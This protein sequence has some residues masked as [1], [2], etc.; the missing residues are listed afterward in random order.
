M[1]VMWQSNMTRKTRSVGSN[2]KKWGPAAMAGRPLGESQILG[3]SFC[4]FEN[5]KD[6]RGGRSRERDIEKVSP[7]V[8]FCLADCSCESS[9]EGFGAVEAD[10]HEV[11][12]VDC[13]VG[14]Q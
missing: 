10:L 8:L 3:G 11:A 7:P 1:A 12:G 4:L 6:I 9:T 5:Q 13:V 2:K 14:I